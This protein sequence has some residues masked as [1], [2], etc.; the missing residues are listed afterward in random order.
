MPSQTAQPDSTRYAY[1]AYWAANFTTCA[2]SEKPCLDPLLKTQQCLF[3]TVRRS[4]SLV[5]RSAGT[6]AAAQCSEAAVACPP[7]G[8]RARGGGLLVRS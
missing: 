2:W 7:P 3:F 4:R 1:P 6:D 5:L 8:T